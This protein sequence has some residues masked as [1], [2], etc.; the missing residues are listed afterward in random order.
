MKRNFHVA[1]RT[2]C[3]AGHTHDS[4]AE[5]KRC[6]ALHL[7][8]RAGQITGLRVHPRFHFVIDGREV[9][10]GNGHVARYTADFTYVEGNRQRVE[11]VKPSGGL[12]E[13]DF[14]LRFALAKHC[15]PDI[16]FRVVK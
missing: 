2:I 8:Q 11:D 4:K 6:D 9:K 10:M 16:D 7:L 14:R 15:F 12:I 3:A 1:R 13:R 5:A